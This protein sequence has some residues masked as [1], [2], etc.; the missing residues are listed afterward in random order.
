M[1]HR[2]SL[3]D[4]K[5]SETIYSNNLNSEIKVLEE[6]QEFN[7]SGFQKFGG[8]RGCLNFEKYHELK[9]LKKFYEIHE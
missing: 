4:D 6:F 1:S 5:Y 8:N 3:S 7:A 9:G 2:S